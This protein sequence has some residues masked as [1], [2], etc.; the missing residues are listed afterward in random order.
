MNDS[1]IDLRDGHPAELPLNPAMRRRLVREWRHPRFG[2]ANPERMNNPVW[3]W[4]ARSQ[5]EGKWLARSED[6]TYWAK[7]LLGP[8]A[9]NAAPRWIFQ[10]NGQSSTTLADGRVVLI[11]GEHE[12]S[13]DP[14]FYIYND[15]V[16]LHPDGRLDIFGYPEEVFPPTDSHAA[17]LAGE[18]IVIIGGLGYPEGRKVGT[19]PVFVLDLNTFSISPVAASGSAPGWIHGHTADL[20]EDG[21]SIVVRG[22]STIGGS[23][24]ESHLR[25][26]DDWRF[27]LTDWRWERLTECQWQQWEVRR[28][29]GE[30]THLVQIQSVLRLRHSPSHLIEFQRRMKDE[31]GIPSLE[32]ELG[33][34]PDLEVAARLYRPEVEHEAMPDVADEVWVHRIKIAGVV[35]RYDQDMGGVQVTVE[36]ELPQPAIDAV[37]CDL[38]K[39]LCMLENAPCVARQLQLTQSKP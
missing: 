12:D 14:D 9:C 18:K 36:G 28:S 10:R 34:P 5:L 17:T 31:F 32:E 19:T 3:E 8:S 33:A 26:C 7:H 37:I 27:D 38:R 22:G 16:V 13:Y 39:K 4:L 6:D 20:A 21:G 23:D 24:G 2:R 15:V 11:G 29:D 25:N 35:V 30:P 1:S